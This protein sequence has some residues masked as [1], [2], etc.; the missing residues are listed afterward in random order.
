[1]YYFV[2]NFKCYLNLLIFDFIDIYYLIML[3]I[4]ISQLPG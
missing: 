2:Y 4:L 1:M 3:F